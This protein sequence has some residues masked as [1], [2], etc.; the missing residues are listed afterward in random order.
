[1]NADAGGQGRSLCVI[2]KAEY[3]V[4]RLFVPLFVVF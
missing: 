1:M 4:R 3:V 2:E